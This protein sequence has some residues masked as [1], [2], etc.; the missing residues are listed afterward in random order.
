MTPRERSMKVLHGEIPDRVPVMPGFGSWYAS[1]IYGGDMFDVAEGRLSAADMMSELTKKYGCEMWYWQGYIDTISE[2][3]LDGKQESRVDK[4]WINDD[5]YEET[6]ALITPSGEITATYRYN[7]INPA[8]NIKG[9]IV[10]PNRDWH[11]YREFMGDNWEFGTTTTLSDVP[12]EALD[13]GVTCY[14]IRLPVDLWKDL[15]CDTGVTLTEL[16]DGGTLMDEMKEWH[17]HYS[18]SVL[19]ARMKIDPLPD[20]I[21][22]QGSSSSLSMISPDIYRK[23]NL[24]FIQ[25]ACEIAHSKNVPVQIH[26]CG[27][28][29]KLVEI[30]YHETD[31]DVIHPLESFP[32]GDVDLA[33]VK[34]KFGDKIVLMGNLNTYELMLKG[35]P[36]EVKDAAKKAINDAAEGGRFIL[37]NGD[38]LGRDTPEENIIAMVEAAYEYG[39][40]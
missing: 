15:R 7:R 36:S 23:Y 19:E 33:E 38:Q 31:V 21:H 39:C 1:R 40:Y 29:A 28:S 30:L 24:E 5:N 17:T 11:I 6:I 35:S 4:V 37:A 2:K 26:H 14:G 20:M 9:F 13:L 3:S 34:K 22:L 16:Y 25:R 8:V 10:E 18:M 12:K 27:K 32:G